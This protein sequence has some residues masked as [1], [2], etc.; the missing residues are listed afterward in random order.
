MEIAASRLTPQRRLWRLLAAVLSL[1]LVAATCEGS[2]DTGPPPDGDGD[3][4]DRA[5]VPQEELTLG[6][7]PWKEAVANTFL[8]KEILERKGYN[9]EAERLEV[10]AVFAGVAGGDVD[11]FLD[12]WLPHTHE[13]YMDEFGDNVVTLGTWFDEATSELAVPTYVAENEGITSLDELAEDPELFDSDGDGEG[14]I[15][16]VERSARVMRLLREKVMPAYG[17][18]EDFTLLEGSTVAMRADLEAAYEAE[19]PIVITLW[20]P[21]PEYGLKEL[22]RLEDPKGAWGEPEHLDVIARDGF[23]SDFPR[24]AEWLEAFEFTE[25]PLAELQ[26]SVEEADD[27]DEQRAAAEWLDDNPGVVNDWLGDESVGADETS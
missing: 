26:A 17:L 27:G 2:G 15:T 13:R 8:W 24:V 9:V 7:I 20:T 19:E 3:G 22:T 1:A 11:V 14:E 5:D 10:P 25:E 23:A 21:H 6:W 12:V 4:D 18:E 16:G